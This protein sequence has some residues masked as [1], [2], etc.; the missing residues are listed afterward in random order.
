MI[1]TINKIIFFL[2]FS[3]LVF[4]IYLSTFGIKTDRFNNIIEKQLIK[5]DQ[6]ISYNLND[7]NIKLYAFDFKLKINTQNPEI[8]FN[9][10]RLLFKNISSDIPIKFL[11]NKN[12]KINNLN[13]QSE[14]NNLKNLITFIRIYQNNFNTLLLDKLINKGEIIFNVKLEFDDNGNIKPNFLINGNIK[15]LNLNLLNKEKIESKF[16]FKIK[17]NE[18]TIEESNI[19]YK[20]LNLNSKKIE[21]FKKNG[22]FNIKGDFSNEFTNIDKK[23]IK[24]TL[25]I[26]NH[27]ENEKITFKSNNK[28]DFNIDK[29]YK[30]SNIKIDSS[31][32]VKEIIYDV[33]NEKIRD[34]FDIDDYIR[35]INHKLKVNLKSDSLENFKNSEIIIQGK[36]DIKSKNYKDPFTY[37]YVRNDKKKNLNLNFEINEHPINLKLIKYE[38]KKKISSN[39]LADISFK[40]DKSVNIKNLKFKEN[41]NQMECNNLIIS[42]KIKIADFD[43]LFLNFKNNK[44]INNKIIITKEKKNYLIEGTTFDASEIINNLLDSNDK[45]PIFDISNTKILLNI[46]NFYIDNKNF[47]SITKGDI[48]IKDSHIVQLNIDSIFP[49]NKTLRINIY[50]NNKGHK[51]TTL[52]TKFPKPLISRYSF[53]KG[54]EEGYLNFR[55]VRINNK[56]YSTL[57]IDNFK[58]QEVPVLAKLLTLASLQGI[59]DLLTGEGIRFTDFEMKFTQS[60]NLTEIDEIYA[61]GPAISILMEGYIEKKKV[62]S[63][64]GTLVPATTINRTI[65][66]IPILGDI[67]VGKKV[68]EGVFGVSFKIKG[69]PKDLKTTVNP[70]KTLTPR[71]ITRTLEK[72]KN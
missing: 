7:I 6:K 19:L 44:Q 4:I 52:T 29:K 37:D 70:I 16:Y 40:E 12:K 47:L 63:L 51:I 50:I 27:I 5:H 18:A 38:K 61:I 43:K 28:F 39:L 24:Y 25:G 69:P 36:G 30:L 58:V 11:F 66:S 13:I 14:K 41:I 26:L 23:L 1:N 45:E 31:L 10:K 33:R 55:S 56:N 34:I 32:E 49:N 8:L 53:I 42:N 65:S 62:T 15:S 20:N 57:I 72:L 68:G 3:I 67:L 64:R 71:F 35:L 9:N 46:K 59:A 54:F 17:K 22:Y 21:V 2:I 48:K 60:Q